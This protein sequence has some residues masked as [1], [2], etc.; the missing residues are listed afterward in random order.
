MDSGGFYNHYDDP[1]ELWD[2]APLRPIAKPTREPRDPW[3]D[4]S[5]TPSYN[6]PPVAPADPHVRRSGS[7]GANPPETFPGSAS[8]TSLMGFFDFTLDETRLPTG[9]YVNPNLHRRLEPQQF[10]NAATAGYYE[11]LWRIDGPKIFDGDLTKLSSIPSRR[12]EII[13][14]LQSRSLAEFEELERAAWGNFECA[15]YGPKSSFGQPSVTVVADLARIKTIGID[16]RWSSNAKPSDIGYDII[17]CANQIR[18]RRPRYPGGGPWDRRTDD[19]LETELRE[20]K[21]YLARNS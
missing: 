16:P 3:R 13:A 18:V 17:D 6:P 8:T 20:Y 19:E 15:G 21:N 12:L 5:T 2:E 14:L 7:I 4:F 1:D 11:A 10:S 9:I